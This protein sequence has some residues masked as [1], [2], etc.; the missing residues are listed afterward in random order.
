MDA[1]RGDPLQQVHDGVG[2]VELRGGAVGDLLLRVAALLRDDPRGSR[3]VH[4]GGPGADVSGEHPR[5]SVRSHAAVLEQE[6]AEPALLL[7]AP[8][9]PLSHTGRLY[10]KTAAAPSCGGG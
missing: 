1:V 8:H 10:Q 4:Q 5:R 7:R 6:A 2:C 9:L 3:Q